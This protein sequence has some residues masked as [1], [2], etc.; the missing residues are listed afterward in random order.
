MFNSSD[1]GMYTIPCVV[2]VFLVFVAKG[3][4]IIL[5]LLRPRG[6]GAGRDSPVSWKPLIRFLLII[7]DF[8]TFCVFSSDTNCYLVS[9]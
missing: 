2:T 1:I 5:R 8:S 6:L 3:I 4:Y 7:Y 9:F